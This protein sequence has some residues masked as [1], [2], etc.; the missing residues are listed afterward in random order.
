MVTWWGQL[1]RFGM[2][3]NMMFFN[4]ET[5]RGRNNV[6]SWSKV[7]QTDSVHLM[8][9]WMQPSTG[10]FSDGLVEQQERWLFSTELWIILLH[11]LHVQSRVL[12]VLPAD[13]IRRVVQRKSG[14]G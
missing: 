3:S 14:G 5:R 1:A 6:L 4:S 8:R 11:R 13:N 12:L 2:R 10:I 7:R 9:F